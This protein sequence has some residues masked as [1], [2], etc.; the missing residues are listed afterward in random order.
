MIQQ[1]GW[2]V[3]CQEVKVEGNTT[4]GEG[5]RLFKEMEEVREA[6]F[7]IQKMNL[8]QMQFIVNRIS[9]IVQ[10]IRDIKRN[11]TTRCRNNPSKEGTYGRGEEHCSNFSYNTP[12]HQSTPDNPGRCQEYG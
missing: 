7:F 10:E 4:F 1:V 9:K 5:A 8:S 3:S 2:G 6:M 12:Q 11:A